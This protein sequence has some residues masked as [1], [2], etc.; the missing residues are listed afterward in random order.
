MK[1]RA[2][3]STL[4]A[5]TKGLP[6]V[7]KERRAR[8]ESKG[9]VYGELH[10]WTMRQP[11]ILASENVIHQ[12]KSYPGRGFI[13]SHHVKSVATGGEDY[14]NTLPVCAAGHDEFHRRGLTGMCETYRRDWRSLACEVTAQYLAEATE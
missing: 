11:C 13:E 8:R 5:P 12:C 1:R 9:R 10:R 14:N 7:N 4:P 3:N 2:W 6:K